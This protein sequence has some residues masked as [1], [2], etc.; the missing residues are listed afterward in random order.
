M[1]M[2]TG[3]GVVMGVVLPCWLVLVLVYSWTGIV[4][5]RLNGEKRGEGTG[6]CERVKNGSSRQ[7]FLGQTDGWLGVLVSFDQWAGIEKTAVGRD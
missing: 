4:K 6:L 3:F 1:C 7:G 2:C 5:P